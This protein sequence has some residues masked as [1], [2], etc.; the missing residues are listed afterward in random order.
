MPLPRI[1]RNIEQK[2]SSPLKIKRVKFVKILSSNSPSFFSA[3]Q[4]HSR[5][6]P[7]PY[8]SPTYT[9]THTQ[10]QTRVHGFFRFNDFWGKRGEGRGEGIAKERSAIRGKTWMNG[11]KIWD[12]VRGPVFEV[13]EKGDRGKGAQPFICLGEACR[14]RAPRH[15]LTVSTNFTPNFQLA[16]TPPDLHNILEIFYKISPPL[17]PSPLSPSLAR[18]QLHC[19]RPASPLFSFLRPV[20]ERPRRQMGTCRCSDEYHALHQGLRGQGW[21]K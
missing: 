14:V 7:L 19:N 21:W 1:P 12:I 20:D 17:P 9:D 15:T 11:V 3:R 10:I 5:F 18:A 16:R 6:L 13:F 4:I 8:K 2:N